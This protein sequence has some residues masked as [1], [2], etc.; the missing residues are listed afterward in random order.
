MSNLLLH[1]A[2]SHETYS[3]FIFGTVSEKGCRWKLLP[4]HNGGAIDEHLSD[5]HATAGGMVEWQRTIEDVIIPKVSDTMD[6]GSDVN[7]TWMRDHRSFWKTCRARCVDVEQFVVMARSF[8]LICWRWIAW[9]LWREQLEIFGVGHRWQVD[10]IVE[11]EEFDFWAELG[12]N[13]FDC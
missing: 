11:L 2:Y 12:F 8:D 9:H 10:F 1:Y 3:C 5:R 4:Q 7:V 6:C 13:L